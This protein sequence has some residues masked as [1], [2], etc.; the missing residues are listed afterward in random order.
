[1]LDTMEGK[2]FNERHFLSCLFEWYKSNIW[3]YDAWRAKHFPSC[4][5]SFWIILKCRIFFFGEIQVI[6]KSSKP[7]EHVL[8]VN[9]S[10]ENH[11]RSTLYGLERTDMFEHLPSCFEIRLPSRESLLCTSLSS[12]L[13]VRAS[14]IRTFATKEICHNQIENN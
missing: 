13:H 10:K 3:N 4:F 2:V 11:A 9:S 14:F 7:H 8:R 1:M 5:F 12:F 6:Q